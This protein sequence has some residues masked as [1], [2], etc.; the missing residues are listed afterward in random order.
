[1]SHA[2]DFA[3][4]VPEDLKESIGIQLD[5]FAAEHKLR[6]LRDRLNV[7][8]NEVGILAFEKTRKMVQAV[9][10]RVAGDQQKG[11]DLYVAVTGMCVDIQHSGP[12]DYASELNDPKSEAARLWHIITFANTREFKKEDGTNLKSGN[13]QVLNNKEFAMDIERIMGNLEQ[14]ALDPNAFFIEARQSILE[15]VDKF[16][17]RLESFA[18]KDKK[19]GRGGSKSV[20]EK[21][22]KGKD[23]KNQ[24]WDTSAFAPI[25]DKFEGFMVMAMKGAEGGIVKSDDG[26]VFVGARGEIDDG[27]IESCGLVA[28]EKVEYDRAGSTRRLKYFRPVGSSADNAHD[29]IKKV[30]GGFLVIL[31]R[32]L[33]LAKSIVEALAHKKEAVKVAEESL[34]HTRVIQTSEGEGEEFNKEEEWKKLAFL[35]P[36]A[37]HDLEPSNARSSETAL[38]RQKDLFYE[39]LWNIRSKFI[40]LDV[41]NSLEQDRT[42]KGQEV[43]EYDKARLI[44]S[45]G[46]KMR[47]KVEEIMYINEVIDK[48]LDALPPDVRRVID[49][50]GGAGDV[51]LGVTMELLS[52]GRKIDNVEIVDPQESTDDFMRTIIANFPPGLRMQF[53]KIAHHALEHGTGYLQE[54]QITPDAVVVAKHA[55]GTLTDDIIHQWKNS[56]SKLLV[57]MTC[58]QDK[59]CGHP[60]RYGFSQEDWDRLTMETG[61]TNLEDEI[62]RSSGNKKEQLQAKLEKGK[63]AMVIMD[64]ARVNYLRRHG[65]AA[66]LLTTDKFPKGDV[67][68]A[69]RLPKD[70]PARLA[71]LEKLEKE[72]PTKFDAMILRLDRLARKGDVD[73]L[74][75]EYGADWV[76]ADFKELIKHFEA[77]APPAVNSKP[78]L[79]AKKEN[80]VQ[81]EQ[82]QR[83]ISVFGVKLAEHLKKLGVP[84]GKPFGQALALAKK[85]VLELNNAPPEEVRTAIEQV[86]MLYIK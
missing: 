59:A 48:H 57:A 35:R 46:E 3:S 56:E 38:V 1:M 75:A 24:E 76:D 72:T 11:G 50:A 64:S 47:Q 15:G 32:N 70:F 30:H 13:D 49:M 10:E 78:Q 29:V 25:A 84:D 34:G 16:G 14:A 71:A 36:K 4:H 81:S 73:N 42:K 45:I 27:L 69:R 7:G 41:L 80:K 26:E 43:T 54:T 60:A 66:E 28:E 33:D 53:E 85:R 17:I 6:P 20:P 83:E 40:Y 86:A 18:K 55:C 77:K 9:C 44:D 22:I 8:L 74:R 51:G 58:C 12:W 65:F 39:S 82:E 37:T 31:T 5:A 23:V 79:E 67:I 63:A 61:W 19:S 21:I 62:E 68:I 2:R 52:R